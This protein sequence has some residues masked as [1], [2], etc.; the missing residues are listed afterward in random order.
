MHRKSFWAFVVRTLLVSLLLLGMAAGCSPDVPEQEEQPPEDVSGETEKIE[1]EVPLMYDQRAIVI[2]HQP[3]K[4]ASYQER[5]VASLRTVAAEVTVADWN[6]VTDD[7]FDAQKTAVLILTG[8]N[9]VEGTLLEK[10]EKFQKKG[11][12]LIALGGPLCEDIAYQRAGGKYSTFNEFMTTSD[13]VHL[14]IDFEDDKQV[15]KIGR[16]ANNPSVKRKITTGDYGLDRTSLKLENGY[17]EGWDLMTI[18]MQVEEDDSML[19]F[20][21]KA[22]GAKTMYIEIVMADGTRW[23]GPT[24]QTSEDWTF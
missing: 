14:Q 8:A 13:D 22:S 5:L 12:H 9:R 1:E 15:A 21:A 16:N 17:Y 24:L 19:C 4:A 2:L 11:G 23:L 20:Y 10:A 18:P 6:T 7:A 3:G